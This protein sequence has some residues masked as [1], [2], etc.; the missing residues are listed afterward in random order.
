MKHHATIGHCDHETCIVKAHD[1]DISG[2]RKVA[3][4][5]EVGCTGQ[6]P[7]SNKGYSEA[8]HA[9]ALRQSALL[10]TEFQ[11]I[12]T[13]GKEDDQ[14]PLNGCCKDN[15]GHNG[16][17]SPHIEQGHGGEQSTEYAIDRLKCKL[18]QLS[19]SFQ[20]GGFT[21]SKCKESYRRRKGNEM[22]GVVAPGESEAVEQRT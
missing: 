17:L 16:C 3:S 21:G 11:R 2:M 5:D 6:D 12:T 22:Q 19:G 13:Q 4:D 7:R 8:H 20:N 18:A 14:H 10:E 9:V 1:L 15:N